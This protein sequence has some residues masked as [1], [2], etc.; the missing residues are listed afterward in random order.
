MARNNARKL[1]LGL[2]GGSASFS[3]LT[4]PGIAL[5]LDA[6]DASTLFQV[7]NGTTPAAADG[8]PIGYWGDKSGAGRHAIQATAGNKPV[9]KLAAKNGKN[10]VRFTTTDDN[11]AV[12][13]TITQPSTYWVVAIKTA[14]G[15]YFDGNTGSPRNLLIDGP[16]V[17]AA[18]GTNLMTAGVT[19]TNWNIFTVTF[20]G[21]SSS[22]RANG[23]SVASGNAGT[24]EPT[25][26]RIGSSISQTTGLS[27]DIAE[28]IVAIGAQSASTITAVESYLNAKWG[29]Y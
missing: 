1:L 15:F 8:D 23:A 6:N 27:G 5:W 24:N 12:T 3:P 25:G 22:I 29:A 13:M 4:I 16:P 17:Y 21:L 7:E 19:S 10:T 14:G 20:N 11:V 18:A 9:L 26:L 28:F 2:L